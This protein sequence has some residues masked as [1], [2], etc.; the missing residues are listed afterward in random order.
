MQPIERER[1]GKSRKLVNTEQRARFDGSKVGFIT[2]GL[3]NSRG[4]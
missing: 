2:V 4:D 3:G 1:G